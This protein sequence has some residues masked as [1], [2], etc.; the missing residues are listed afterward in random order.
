MTTTS[1]RT[2]RPCRPCT[3]CSARTCTSSRSRSATCGRARSAPLPTRGSPI[4][5]STAWQRFPVPPTARW[6]WR[7]R[8]SPSART[9][10]FETS[11]SRRRCLLDEETSVSSDATVAAPG[12][13]DFAVETHQN[14][15]RIRRAAA[16]L[17]RHRRRARPRN[18]TT[19]PR[20]IAAHPS[21]LDGAELR[22]GFDSVGI[23]YGPAFTGLVAAHVGDGGEG[24]VDTVFAEVALPGLIRSQQ[25]AYGSHPALL[26]ACFQSVIVH[27]EVQNAAAGGGSAVA[28][29]RTPDSLL[30]ADPQRA[31]LPDPGHRLQD[32]RVRSRPRRA[33][34]SP[35]P[36]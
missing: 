29:R 15:D 20:L 16:V 2:A 6:P 8:S 26:D 21:G 12:V 14:G 4:T 5:R 28:G 32:R 1:R 31:L 10:R 3:R 19:S 35:A 13:L 22:K 23:Q 18:R 30:P 36:C 17:A 33:W 11:A 25:A 27:P 24:S 34:I 9:P 7:Q